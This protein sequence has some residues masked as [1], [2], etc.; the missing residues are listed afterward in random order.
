METKIKT[1]LIGIAF[2]VIVI[3]TIMTVFASTT[4]AVP[5]GGGAA[6]TIGGLF[7]Q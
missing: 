7:L 1:K 3:L 2:L 5:C 6:T 4:K